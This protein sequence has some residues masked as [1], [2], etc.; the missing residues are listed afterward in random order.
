MP[1]SMGIATAAEEFA[2]AMQKKFPVVNPW[3]S[4]FEV[5]EGKLYDRI[6]KKHP[7]GQSTVFAFVVR[8]SGA[9]VKAASWKA[10]A[11]RVD[12]SFATKYNLYNPD[13]FRAAVDAADPHGSF[14]YANA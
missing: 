13:E 14:L 6:V 7:G 10:P 5:Q 9:L 2:D 1:D 8:S 12:G 11:K 3:D 4:I